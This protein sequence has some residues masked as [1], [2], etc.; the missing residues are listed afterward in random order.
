[1]VKRNSISYRGLEP[2]LYVCRGLIK[3]EMMLR[4]VFCFV[5]ISKHERQSGCSGCVTLTGQKFIDF[6]LDRRQKLNCSQYPLCQFE[7]SICRLRLKNKE[8]YSVLEDNP[9]NNNHITGQK[10]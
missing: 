4:V 9:K 3:A 1:M 10:L 5:R 6:L 8:S 7:R 2:C